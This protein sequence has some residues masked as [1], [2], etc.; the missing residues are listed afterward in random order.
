MLGDLQAWLP[1]CRKT[2]HTHSCCSK[3]RVPRRAPRRAGFNVFRFM[4]DDF[5]YEMAAL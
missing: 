3:R 5:V 4:N 1:L 2:L